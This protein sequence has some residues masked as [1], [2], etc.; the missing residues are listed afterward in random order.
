MHLL[1]LTR[2]GCHLCDEMEALL[3]TELP[4]LGAT[5]EA[6]NVDHDPGLRQRY[7]DVI[8]VLMR[9]GKAVAKVRCSAAQL[10]RIVARKR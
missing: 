5:Y 4:Q 10:R 6:F 9:D 3:A 8:P 7:G 2:P 1:F